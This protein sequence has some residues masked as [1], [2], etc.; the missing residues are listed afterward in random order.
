MNIPERFQ[1][2]EYSR[3]WMCIWNGTISELEL[4]SE[5]SK[6]GTFS[7]EFN[8]QV[9]V[10][11]GN[12]AMGEERRCTKSGSSSCLFIVHVSQFWNRPN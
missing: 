12:V 6:I 3:I 1:N 4:K 2:V 11:Q 9:L 10:E 7:L 8:G 5:K